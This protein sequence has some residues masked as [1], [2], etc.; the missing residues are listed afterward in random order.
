MQEEI[1]YVFHFSLKDLKNMNSQELVR[2][3]KAAVR[4]NKQ[5]NG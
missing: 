5:V 1:V 4:I 3:H 2:W